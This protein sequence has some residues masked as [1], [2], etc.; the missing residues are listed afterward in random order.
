MGTRILAL[1]QGQQFVQQFALGI[2][3]S[4]EFSHC[5][6]Q[7]HIGEVVLVACN[8]VELQE[9]KCLDTI[10]IR[11]YHTYVHRHIR[12]RLNIVLRHKQIFQQHL[13]VQLE[14]F[15]LGQHTTALRHT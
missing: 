3:E 7:K 6:L 10:S 1:D 5:N 14:R 12:T 9:N 2:G 15:V 13:D 11:I 8:K 4:L